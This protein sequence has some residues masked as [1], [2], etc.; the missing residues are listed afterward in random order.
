MA[1]MVKRILGLM[2]LVAGLLIVSVSQA[3]ATPD[4]DALRGGV[5]DLDTLALTTALGDDVFSLVDLTTVLPLADPGNASDHHFGPFT[6]ASDP[7]HGSCQTGNNGTNIW[8]N[9]TGLA[10]FFN[11]GGGAPDGTIKVREQFKFGSFTS[12]GNNPSPG[13]CN[14]GSFSNGGTLQS[15]VTGGTHGYALLFVSGATLN[16]GGNPYGPGQCPTFSNT[17]NPTGPS[18]CKA[19][20][21][22]CLNFK[23]TSF[24]PLTPCN[25][26]TQG[27]GLTFTQPTYFFHYNASNP[28]SY[29]PALTQNEWKD[30]VK[31]NQLAQN[32][33]IRNN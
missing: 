29:T 11:V 26:G 5:V 18:F 25:P 17:Q 30:A 21:F 33:D 7:D 9:D 13:S 3:F 10:R 19:S 14:N 22:I 8:A 31:N 6:N 2:T 23:A 28:Q 27:Y 24:N 1:A 16:P 15:G 4:G 32:G 12:N 20:T